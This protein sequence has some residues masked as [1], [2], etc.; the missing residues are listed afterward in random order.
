VNDYLENVLEYLSKT[1]GLALLVDQPWN[2]IAIMKFR[3]GST[4]AG[5]SFVVATTE[6]IPLLLLQSLL[7]EV[8][9]TELRELGDPP[10][11]QTSHDAYKDD[12]V[13]HEHP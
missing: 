2:R 12:I 4:R 8:A 3:L 11:A 9:Q 13:S 6:C 10:S 1:N 5:S 7:H